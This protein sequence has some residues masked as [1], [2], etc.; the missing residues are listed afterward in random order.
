M[1]SSKKML[2]DYFS[3]KK[4]LYHYLHMAESNY[5]NY[6]KGEVV[7]L[8]KYF[9]VLRPLL[10][11][12]WVINQKCPPPVLFAELMEAEL[13]K[14]LVPEVERL[15]KMKQRVPE[16]GE[17]LKISVLNEYFDKILEEIRT[18]TARVEKVDVSWEK[19]NT[20]FLN[21]VVHK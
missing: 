13:E 5:R 1:K 16:M 12:K 14:C 17:A 11:T 19:L 7:Q 18:E 9:Y 15:L 20:F 6:L 3:I 10:A 8:K 2:P 4:S 21:L